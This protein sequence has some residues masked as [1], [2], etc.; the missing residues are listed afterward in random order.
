MLVRHSFVR[1]R[2]LHACQWDAFSAAVLAE[3]ALALVFGAALAL[4]EAAVSSLR[5]AALMSLK[6]VVGEHFFIGSSLGKSP[7]SGLKAVMGSSPEYSIQDSEPLMHP[8]SSA[9]AVAA[10]EVRDVQ[11]AWTNFGL[12][13]WSPGPLEILETREM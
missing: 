6:Q 7:N 2:P 5:R 4:V 10:E 1:L 12:K 11:N 13:F 8:S 3:V 9:M